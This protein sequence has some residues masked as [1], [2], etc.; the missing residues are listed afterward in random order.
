MTLESTSKFFD[1]LSIAGYKYLGY[2]GLSYSLCMI[3]LCKSLGISG[4]ISYAVNLYFYISNSF[5]VV[6]CPPNN[7]FHSVRRLGK[8]NNTVT[9]NARKSR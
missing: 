8:K 3:L 2:M 7:K 4:Y 6:R 9:Q 1:I 5:L